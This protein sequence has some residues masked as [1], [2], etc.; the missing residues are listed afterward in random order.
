M[1]GSEGISE[2]KRFG[3]GVE[4]G[5]ARL[6]RVRADGARASQTVYSLVPVVLVTGVLPGMRAENMLG[7]LM[8]YHSLRVKGSTGFFFPAIFPFF[9]NFL[10]L[11]T[12]C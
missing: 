5:E 1:G 3:V 2:E 7:A 8:S 11:P 10:F 9:P 4:A 12:A 6:Q